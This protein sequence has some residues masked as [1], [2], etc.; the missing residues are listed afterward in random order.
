MNNHKYEQKL[1]VIKL[2]SLEY[3]TA[4]GDM[5]ETLKMMHSFY[6]PGTVCSL[7]LS[8]FTPFNLHKKTVLT[9][10]YAHLFPST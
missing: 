8:L 4:G 6:N 3:R 1:M 7:F 5:T 10:H 2:P 9:Y